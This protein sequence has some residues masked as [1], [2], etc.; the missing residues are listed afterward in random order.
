VNF[1]GVPRVL[2]SIPE[3]LVRQIITWWAFK[4]LCNWETLYQGL[5]C[6]STLELL[7]PCPGPQVSILNTWQKRRD[8]SAG[9]DPSATTTKP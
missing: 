7:H 3:R 1:R 6:L 2:H 5:A 9:V 4:E 8:A